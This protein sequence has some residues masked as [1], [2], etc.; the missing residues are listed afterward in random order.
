MISL[1]HEGLPRTLVPRDGLRIKTERCALLPC[2]LAVIAWSTITGQVH[3]PVA[4]FPAQWMHDDESRRLVPVYSIVANPCHSA[5][6][7]SKRRSNTS[8][9]MAADVAR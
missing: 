2:C 7:L 9:A 4:T 1:Q 3:S 5:R 8:S 6:S